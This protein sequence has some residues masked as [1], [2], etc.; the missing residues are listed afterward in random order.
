MGAPLFLIIEAGICVLILYV[1]LGKFGLSTYKCALFFALLAPLPYP[2]GFPSV[3]WLPSPLVAP[4]LHWFY[5]ILTIPLA[6]C[7]FIGF[8]MLF[9][10]IRFFLNRKGA[11]DKK[12]LIRYYFTIGMIVALA[13][14]L[15][16]LIVSSRIANFNSNKI[17]SAKIYCDSLP[18]NTKF[19][20]I[21]HQISEKIFSSPLA[22]HFLDVSPEKYVA[23][24]KDENGAILAYLTNEKMVSTDRIDLGSDM[25]YSPTATQKKMM[26]EFRLSTGIVGR[27][28]PDGLNFEKELSKCSYSSFFEYGR[29]SQLFCFDMDDLLK[30]KICSFPKLAD[31][32]PATMSIEDDFFNKILRSSIGE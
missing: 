6:F 15:T 19:V 27:E 16:P 8:L 11:C 7:Y 22:I 4:G 23:A 17:A 10:V 9:F 12:R 14:G 25:N 32:Q 28:F 30:V 21:D 13:G 18:F 1:L 26:E 3:S 5:F 31:S 29:G 20:D 2:M 24:E